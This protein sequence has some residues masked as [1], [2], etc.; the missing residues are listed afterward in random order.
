MYKMLTVSNITYRYIKTTGAKL[1]EVAVAPRAVP[2][3]STQY[4]IAAHIDAGK[5]TTT[6]RIPF[7][8]ASFTKLAKST[9]N[10]RNRLDG[11]RA[12]ARI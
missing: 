12:G 5:T 2:Q 11:T 6:E 9:R 7:T 8:R 10:S 1:K 4:R 3:K